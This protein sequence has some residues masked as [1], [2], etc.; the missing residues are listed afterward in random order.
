M[1]IN[2]LLYYIQ[3]KYYCLSFYELACTLRGDDGGNKISCVLALRASKAEGDNWEGLCSSGLEL[4]DR[5]SGM[6]LLLKFIGG[7]P[8]ARTY[9]DRKAWNVGC[10]GALG[11][12]CIPNAGLNIGGNG[13]V[14]Q[15]WSLCIC[16]RATGP[17]MVNSGIPW[18]LGCMNE[19]ASLP[20]AFSRFLHFARLFWN[21]TWKN[22]RLLLI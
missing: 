1:M 2:N 13:I 9:C 21:H 19:T 22:K 10:I 7:T 16:G 4:L 14:G 20:M 18:S 15:K 6:G 12:Q 3:I 5:S 17:W 8:P 11:G